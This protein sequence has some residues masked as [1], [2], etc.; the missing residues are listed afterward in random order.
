MNKE[1]SPENDCIYDTITKAYET[2]LYS[3]QEAF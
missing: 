3:G 2:G 1:K